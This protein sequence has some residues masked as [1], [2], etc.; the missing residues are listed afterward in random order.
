MRAGPGRPARVDATEIGAAVLAVGF[1]DLT[2]TAVA[3]HLRIGQATLYRHAANRAELVRLGLELAVNR[4]SWPGLDGGWR[5]VLESWALAA[6]HVCAEH[7]G[8]A[9]E[10]TRGVAPDAVA[11]LSGRLG[12][13]LVS[14]G[15]TAAD[16]VLA[17]DLVLDLVVDSRRGVD[18]LTI[19]AV[20]DLTVTAVDDLTF[21]AVEG[22]RTA[23]RDH[24]AGQW[25][26]PDVDPAVPAIRAEMAQVIR[27]DPTGWFRGRL[28]V[29]LTGVEH[30][31]SPSGS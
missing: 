30:E 19:T 31:L 12:A 17:V 20:D 26:V 15:F 11:A 4:V 9:A 27:A 10:M 21:T 29:V 5:Q 6:W 18:D 23:M 2:F 7:P 22:G 14:H 3:A 8:A 28:R 13:L 24:S 16:A 25:P 1:R